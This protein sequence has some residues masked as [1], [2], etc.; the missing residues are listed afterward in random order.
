MG[1]RGS[2]G[3]VGVVSC[4]A[5]LVL[6][7]KGEPVVLATPTS[8]KPPWFLV[9]PCCLEVTSLF[10]DG[11]SFFSY[12]FFNKDTFLSE[13]LVLSCFLS[14]KPWEFCCS[15]VRRPAKFM[16]LL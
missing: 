8:G 10:T 5:T 9:T 4:S 1:R 13:I 6:A 14:A 11:S 2:E 7:R 16:D 12:R 3:W 15:G